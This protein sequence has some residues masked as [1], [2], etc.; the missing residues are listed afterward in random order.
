MFGAL[1]QQQI[2][3]ASFTHHQYPLSTPQHY[4]RQ[5]VSLTPPRS[6][7]TC[8]SP[9]PVNNIQKA[10]KQLVTINPLSPLSLLFPTTTTAL[11][12]I[13]PR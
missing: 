6:T 7:I 4:F 1:L 2:T 11:F 8:L 12:V 10:R 9:D 5:I 3:T 13:R